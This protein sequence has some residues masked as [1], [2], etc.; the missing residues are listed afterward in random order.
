M[1]YAVLT[2][3]LCLAACAST[4]SHSLTA[5]RAAIDQVRQ[6]IMQAENSGDASVFE[7]VTAPDVVVMPPNS[8]PVSGRQACVNLMRVF[9][10]QF[11][12]K[13][14]Y[15][16]AEIQVDGDS[17]F[18]R[19]SYTQ[20]FKAKAGGD[21]VAGKGSYLWLYKRSPSGKWEQARV[22]WNLN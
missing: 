11:D 13:I 18:D 1:R 21:A 4:G 7:Q 15:A 2:A 14:E 8:Q 17:A 12:L 22:I 3:C 19:G 20:T 6:R 16:S 5:D 9:F 10:Q